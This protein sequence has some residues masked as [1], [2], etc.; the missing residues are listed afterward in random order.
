LCRKIRQNPNINSIPVILLTAKTTV[1][2]NLEGLE[3]GA[4][5]YITKPFNMN[6]LRKTVE[7]LVNGR[8]V[9]RNAYTGKRKQ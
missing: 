5:A 7:N 1:D 8:E 4:D 3:L 6:I 9:L 2:D